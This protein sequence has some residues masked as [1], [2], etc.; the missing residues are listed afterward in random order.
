MAKFTFSSFFEKRIVDQNNISVSDINLGLNNLFT[1]FVV[2]E[3][4]L[5]DDQRYLVSENE[6]NYT[7]LVALHSNL[8][9]ASLW[10]WFMMTNRL[11][12]P[13]KDVEVNYTYSIVGQAQMQNTINDT[14][15]NNIETSNGSN[16]RIGQIIEL[17]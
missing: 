2:N 6:E 15:A 10:W 4:N 12:D 8:Q 17:N 13:L 1:K 16:S 7:D 3:Q 14:W 9:D 5:E 11:D